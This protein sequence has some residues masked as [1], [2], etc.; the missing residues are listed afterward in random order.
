MLAARIGVDDDLARRIKLRFRD[1][2][3]PWTDF[4]F[5]EENSLRCFQYLCQQ[6]YQPICDTGEIKVI[7]E[8]ND[9]MKFKTIRLKSPQRDD[10]GETSYVPHRASQF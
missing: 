8:P 4:Y 6:P 5:D 1:D 2:A 9:T 10:K 7:E 3:I